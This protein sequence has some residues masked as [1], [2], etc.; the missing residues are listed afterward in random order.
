MS[1]GERGQIRREGAT[2]GPQGSA[3]RALPTARQ[4]QPAEGA[5]QHQG[6]S[7][8]ARAPQVLSGSPQAGRGMP[9]GVTVPA[10]GGG[11][12]WDSQGPQPVDGQ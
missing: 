3:A 12:L 7:G 5:G 8:D 9:A 10:Q 11:P 1:R 6:A 4:Q 2:A